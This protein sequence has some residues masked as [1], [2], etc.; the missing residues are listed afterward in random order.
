MNFLLE[1][2]L[3]VAAPVVV[4]GAAWMLMVR[5]YRRNSAALTR[6]MIAGFA[7]KLVLFGAYVAAVLTL[8]PVRPVPF[9]TAF[10]GSFVV[11]YL[12][13]A[14]ALRRLIAGDVPA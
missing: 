8:L 2:L 10:V 4:A 1:I 5:T 11:L 3:G 14:L 13:Q 6:V 12:L 9:V 7:G